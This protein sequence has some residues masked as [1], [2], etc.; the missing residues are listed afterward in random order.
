MPEY[1]RVTDDVKPRREYS[2]PASQV[3][4]AH[5]VLKKPGAFAD[6]TPRPPKYAPAGVSNPATSHEGVE[7]TAAKTVETKEK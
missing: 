3:S 7:N 5:T 4:E 6:G 2:V 1:V